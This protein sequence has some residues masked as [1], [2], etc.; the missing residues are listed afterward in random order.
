MPVAEYSYDPWGRMRNPVN[1]QVYAVGS[2]P[3]LFLGRGFTGHEHLPMFGLVNMNARLYDPVLG[4]FLS[5]DPYVQAPDF[6]DWGQVGISSIVGGVSGFAGGAA[7]SWAA[8]SSIL[9]NN[10]SSSLLRSAV[11]SPIAAG[12]GHIAGGTTVGL[13]RGQS[14]GE[15]FD[16]SFKGIGKSMLMGTAIGVST[17]VGLSFA[18]GMNPLNGKM[19]WPENNGFT[20]I[21][22]QSMLTP[23]DMIDQYG[24][25][26]G[27]FAS[28]HGTS[29]DARSLPPNSSLEPLNI[30]KVAQPIPVLEG[31]ASPSFWF[32]SSGEGTQYRFNN[33]IDYYIQ[34]GYPPKVTS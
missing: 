23:G 22:Q 3:E 29:F 2:E 15:A 9:V 24:S 27:R 30:Y 8:N 34:N 19:L 10:V 28:L 12:A 20:D 7:G 11:V 33:S 1:Q 18:K 17:T 31:T 21:P 25:E 26:S 16:N 6:I 5:P 32:N 4:R 14:L 13:L